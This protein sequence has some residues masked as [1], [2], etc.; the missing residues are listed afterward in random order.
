M[1]FPE[2][3]DGFTLIELLIS[4][5]LATFLAVTIGQ[6]MTISLQTR[7]HLQ[8]EALAARLAENLSLQQ[9]ISQAPPGHLTS[10]LAQGSCTSAFMDLTLLCQA[11]QRLPDLTISKQ[12][13]ALNLRW[14]SPLGEQHL[15]RPLISGAG[16]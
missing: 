16:L 11:K 10:R 14:T 15:Q 5:L 9:A 4:L 2:S 3:Q 13:Q 12:G 6:F 8:Q 7:Q 1:A